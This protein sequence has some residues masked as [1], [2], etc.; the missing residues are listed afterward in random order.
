MSD[1]TPSTRALYDEYRFGRF[2]Y[3][4]KRE[5]FEPPLFEALAGA[6]P[7]TVLYDIGCGAGYWLDT[8]LR[9]GIRKERITAI[10]LA[11]ANVEHLRREGFDA[12]IGNVLGLDID[13]HSSDLTVCIGV[14]NA[15]EDPARAFEELVRITR[16]GGRVYMN[17]Y[18]RGHP[19]HYVVHGATYPIRYLYWNW[20]RTV[21]D[22]AYYVSLPLFQPL[23]RIA[24]GRFL[25]H[26]TGKTMFM[27]RVIAPRAHLFSKSML[28]GYASRCGCTIERFKY[29]R[30]FLMLSAIVRVP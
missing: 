22:V 25:D 24:M 26:Q 21:A 3:G 15:C 4:R 27:D 29:N 30:Y 12:R 2:S 6:G 8:Y 13:A 7:E 11:P 23:A 16:P 1:A 14:L 19:Y 5:E 28:A 9:A 18:T 17:V 20:S 10:D